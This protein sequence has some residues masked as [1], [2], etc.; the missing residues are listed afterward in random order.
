METRLTAQGL[1]AKRITAGIAGVLVCRKA[2]ITRSRLSD[3]ERGHV[4]CEPAELARISDALDF[5][6]EAKAKI[7]RVAVEAG[8]PVAVPG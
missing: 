7:Q 8:W 5:L 1:K 4:S 2:G 6:T 3:I